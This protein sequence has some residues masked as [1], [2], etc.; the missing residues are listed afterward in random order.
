[1]ESR[2]RYPIRFTLETLIGLVDVVRALLMTMFKT[3]RRALLAHLFAGVLSLGGGAPAVAQ[4][5]GNNGMAIP[6]FFFS[7]SERRARE[8]CENRL[9]ECRPAVREQ[10]NFER[11][12]SLFFPWLGLG[13][14]AI[15][16]LSIAR[17]NEKQK[18]AKRRQAQRAHVAGAFKHMG[19]DRPEQQS[20]SAPRDADDRF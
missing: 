13:V 12:I 18:E 2:Q 6:A 4:D 16:V 1:M 11:D 10:M 20:S 15:F 7:G 5:M 14:A 19:E 3:Q 9:P 8:A 17:K